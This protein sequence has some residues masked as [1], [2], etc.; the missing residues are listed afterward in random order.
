MPW[1]CPGCPGEGPSTVLAGDSCPSVHL[2][3]DRR[4][5]GNFRLLSGS[6]RGWAKPSCCWQER[7]VC[8]QAPQWCLLLGNRELTPG[9]KTAHEKDEHPLREL[10][11][12]PTPSDLAL[13]LAH[14]LC[15]QARFQRWLEEPRSGSFQFSLPSLLR[16][17][18]VRGSRRAFQGRTQNPAAL[19]T[20]QHKDLEM[21]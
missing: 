9:E 18:A 16:I 19:R 5:T 4:W 6:L 10:L 14:C 3:G 1:R 11:F 15:T 13:G 17:T 20:N 12:S 8:P 21:A 2:L 7:W